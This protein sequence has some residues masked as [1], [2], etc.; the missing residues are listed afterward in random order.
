MNV[1]L[2]DCSSKTAAY[3]FVTNGELV[4]QKKL[5]V[6]RNA[7]ALL[8]ELKN[9]FEERGLDFSQ[10]DVVSLSNGPG[11]FTGLRIGSVIAKAVC[12]TLG[13]KLVQIPTLDILANMHNSAGQFAAVI[14]SG[15]R[16]GEFYFAGYS[17]SGKL[18]RNTD[19]GTGGIADIAKD[20][21]EIVI[22]EKIDFSEKIEDVSIIDVSG[23][24]GIES[25]LAL[26]G[27]YIERDDFTDITSAEPYYMQ[28]FHAKQN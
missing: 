17:N 2:L 1:L 12:F 11:S 4:F 24:S 7:D 23:Y 20:Y 15:M 18:E 5:E 8:F 14:F 25:Q 9:D 19:Y 10:T 26:T 3:G 16:T 6:N 13:A 28:E 21:K 22:N 27:L